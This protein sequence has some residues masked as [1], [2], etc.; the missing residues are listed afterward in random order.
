MGR[1]RGRRDRESE[2]GELGKRKM[3]TGVLGWC[4]FFTLE[5]LS[6]KA[7]LELLVW[8]KCLFAFTHAGGGCLLLLSRHGLVER[9]GVAL[10]WGESKAV[11]HQSSSTPGTEPAAPSSLLCSCQQTS[12]SCLSEMRLLLQCWFRLSLGTYSCAVY[13]FL[14]FRY[15]P[16]KRASTSK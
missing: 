5:G 12:V 6:R 7:G 4:G 1:K 9:D 16:C 8:R 11:A 3:G 13:Q 15:T 14:F 10:S 2:E